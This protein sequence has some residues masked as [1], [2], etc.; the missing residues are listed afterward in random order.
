[1]MGKRIEG[2]CEKEEGKGVSGEG[3]EG[4]KRDMSGCER[5]RRGR[6]DEEGREGKGEG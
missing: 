4:G 2:R 1:M 6:R 5:R 3:R